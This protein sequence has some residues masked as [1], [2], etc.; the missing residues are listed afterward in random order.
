MPRCFGISFLLLLVPVSEASRNPHWP[1]RGCGLS[2]RTQQYTAGHCPGMPRS[3]REAVT[4]RPRAMG[5]FLHHSVS[6]SGLPGKWIGEHPLLGFKQGHRVPVTGRLTVGNGCPGCFCRTLA[7]RVKCV[8]VGEPPTKTALLSRKGRV[9]RHRPQARAS[10][11]GPAEARCLHGQEPN[12][13]AA[14]SPRGQAE[15]RLLPAQR[16]RIRRR[17]PSHQSLCQQLPGTHVS[18]GSMWTP[19]CLDVVPLCC[20][21][22]D[23]RPGH[24][25]HRAGSG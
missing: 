2:S 6:P 23:H 18:D 19:T 14:K 5:P 20:A 11:E 8:G 25:A 9:E 4:A 10:R 16:V 24:G 15:G 1:Q 22:P 3:F 7:S 12:T 13:S 17:R 21:C